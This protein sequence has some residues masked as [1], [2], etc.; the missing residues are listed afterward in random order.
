MFCLIKFLIFFL[1]GSTLQ[2]T[3]RKPI[4]TQMVLN[5][6]EMINSVFVDT[7]PSVK[8]DDIG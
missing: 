5:Y 6:V 1:L 4:G 2:T 3:A 7:N 8:W